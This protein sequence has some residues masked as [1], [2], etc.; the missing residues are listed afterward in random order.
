MQFATVY[1]YQ[2]I[3]CI[4]KVLTGVPNLKMKQVEN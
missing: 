2:D 1:L 4:R 3:N